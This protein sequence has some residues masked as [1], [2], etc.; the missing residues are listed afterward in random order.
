MIAI[1]VSF[2]CLYRTFGARCGNRT[3]QT[4]VEGWSFTDKLIV[5]FL[6]Q[7]SC[8]WW[9]RS[10]SNRESA[11]YEREAFTIMLRAQYGGGSV[12]LNPRRD[13]PLL[14][15]KTSAFDHSAIPPCWSR[16]SELNRRPREYETRAL[17][18]ELFRHTVRDRGLEPLRITP[19]RLELI[20]SAF[21][22]SR[23]WSRISATIRTP[24]LYKNPALPT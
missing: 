18:T 7:K 3:R 5:H 15:F 13:C 16:I 2:H 9:A 21:H 17:P 19:I 24:E 23:L 8:Q 6:F 1:Y 22:Q 4:S 11:P 20:V 10:G 14:V 12:D